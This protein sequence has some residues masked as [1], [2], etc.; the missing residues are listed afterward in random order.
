MA[1]QQW[2]QDMVVKYFQGYII[3]DEAM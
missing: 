3:Y 2:L 1:V